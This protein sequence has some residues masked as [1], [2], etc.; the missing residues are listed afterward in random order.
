MQSKSVG[1]GGRIR[2]C[3]YPASGAN[4]TRHRILQGGQGGGGQPVARP[5]RLFDGREQRRVGAI[6]L[7]GLRAVG[8]AIQAGHH[9]EA[10]G[11]HRPR[12]E[13]AA[14]AVLVGAEPRRKLELVS[15]E[16]RF[17]RHAVLPR[18]AR[19]TRQPPVLE[20]FRQAVGKTVCDARQGAHR[21]AWIVR[22]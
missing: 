17:E 19:A 18:G 3:G 12:G 8:P 13:Q 5:G 14:E 2:S 1:D 22:H 15:C 10:G 4:Q 20:L 9:P 6:S 7:P 11:E 21:R 16:R